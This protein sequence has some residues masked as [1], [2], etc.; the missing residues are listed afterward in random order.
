MSGSLNSNPFVPQGALNR[1]L[2]SFSFPDNSQYNI[3]AAFL[4]SEGMSPNF[5][6]PVTTM[7]GTMT[8]AVNSPEPYMLV[9]TSVHL[10]RSQ[11][12]A[13]TYRQAMLSNS[14]LGHGILRPDVPTGGP[15]LGSFDFVN[16]NITGVR[17]FAMTGRDA[18]WMITITGIWY[19]NNSLWQ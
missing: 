14:N 5:N 19:V 6:G 16:C 7:L 18:G 8:G 17:P 9:E 2:G 10:I 13:E 3:T 12:F 15:G 1:L 4:G 11:A